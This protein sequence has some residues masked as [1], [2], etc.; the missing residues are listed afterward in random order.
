MPEKNIEVLN[1]HKTFF[2]NYE[3][4]FIEI[5][6]K[7]LH[8]NILSTKEIKLIYH[9][10]FIKP[11]ILKN[12]QIPALINIESKLR[13]YDI[14]LYSILERVF[15][16][17]S[18]NFIKYLLVNQ[19]H[20]SELYELSSICNFYLEYFK[21]HLAKE[22]PLLPEIYE[23]YKNK[24]KITIYNV[25]KGIPISCQTHISSIEKN[26]IIVPSTLNFIVA[27]KFNK[28]IYFNQK[29]K[30][31]YF[32]GE[33]KDFNVTDKTITLTNI[34]KIDRQIPKRKH[35]RVQPKEEI[36][37][38]V[39]SNNTTIKSKLYDI[40]IQGM[41]LILDNN[42]FEISENVE[43]IFTLTVDNKK[44]LLN[45]IG[46]IRSITKIYEHTY[47]YHI[48]FEPN[49]KDEKILE[50]YIVNREKEIINELKQ[51]INNYFF[52]V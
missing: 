27:S 38:I 13:N 35:I 10:L 23:I 11:F 6:S 48:Y 40:S 29:H 41:A 18:N 34:K 45:I 31:Y 46:E 43:T 26:D 21:N 20:Y 7:Q 44:Y 37:V 42:Y 8:E 24:E 17:L 2:K 4:K 22:N 28:E 25:Y 1:K 36:E 16:F 47:K 19:N 51:L 50:K 39:I 5:F 9:V 3:T 33:I 49:P 12:R 14:S 30:N 32:I 15:F 52:F